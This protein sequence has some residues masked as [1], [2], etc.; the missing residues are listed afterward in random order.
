MPQP[1]SITLLFLLTIASAARALTVGSE[2]PLSPPILEAAPFGRSA[3]RIASNGSDFLIV[4][5]DGRAGD[6][7][8]NVTTSSPSAVIAARVDREGNVL[9]PTG[10]MIGIG[11]SLNVASDGRDYVVALRCSRAWDAPICLTRISAETGEVQPGSQVPAPSAAIASN[12]NGYLVAYRAD[13]WIWVISIDAGGLAA[14]SPTRVSA[15]KADPVVASN[16]DSYFVVWEN[17][18]SLS[19]ALITREGRVR[20]GP[21]SP[22][23]QGPG[24]G[25]FTWSISSNDEGYAVAWQQQVTSRTSELRATV[26]SRDG[27]AL[28]SRRI[29]SADRGYP[30]WFPA[31]TWTGSEYFVTFTHADGIYALRMNRSGEIGEPEPFVVRAGTYS[32][33]A[34]A[35]G[36]PATLVAWNRAETYGGGEIEARLLGRGE[37]FLVSR[38]L[39]WQ[40]SITGTTIGSR[41]VV[42]WEET[43]GEEQRRKVFLQR[44]DERGMPLDARGIAVDST[45]LDEVKASLGG[46]M[47]VWMRQERRLVP[48]PGV[49]LAKRLGSDGVPIDE[50][51]IVIGKAVGNG[52]A[53]VAAAGP[54][55]LVAWEAPGNAIVA[56]RLSAEGVL[57]DAQP[58]PIYSGERPAYDPLIAT[59]GV[60]F[61][62]AWHLEVRG[63]CPTSICRGPMM[64][65][66]VLV[67]PLGVVAGAPIE[68]GFEGSLLRSVIWKGSEYVAFWHGYDGFRAQ[69][70]GR[71]LQFLAPP[72]VIS[73]E[74]LPLAVTWTGR[75]YVFAAQDRETRR[76]LIGRLDPDFSI[77]AQELLPSPHFSWS[78]VALFS[79]FVAHE[80]LVDGGISRAVGRELS[81]PMGRRRAVGR[82]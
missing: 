20:V 46:S 66:A 24:S 8:R 4:W 60:N 68:L 38:S 32:G 12:G 3:P 56:A 75:D 27:V 52:R 18:A 44:L 42:A 64:I 62:V 63:G 13:G 36:G 49:V 35:T 48:P 14:G 51:P 69:R 71:D 31:V 50:T 30:L 72:A 11:G 17:Y 45:P 19:S 73:S 47:I 41:R 55:R 23:Y 58:I 67:T 21:I 81:E 65:H 59:D 76:L 82:R 40:E 53:A 15:A 37:A 43:V 6:D 61:L 5:H 33:S 16:G 29:L 1:R 70:V 22:D 2:V 7:D 10:I 74:V 28:L 79:D 54:I 80:R 34:A 39:A 26:V 57:L 9:D 78:P 25:L 77:T